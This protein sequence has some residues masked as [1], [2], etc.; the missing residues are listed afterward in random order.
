MLLLRFRPFARALAGVWIALCLLAAPAAADR[1]RIEAFLK[2]TGFDVA[3]ESIQFAA[4]SAPEMLGVDPG[5]FGSQWERM[6]T[7]VFD[8]DVMLDLGLELLEPTLQDDLLTHA[9]DF[10]AS[11][12]GQRLVE[13][14]NTAH[15]DPDDTARRARGADRMADMVANGSPRIEL[16]Q[17]MTKAIDAS[18]SGARALQEIQFRFLMAASAAGV[19]DLNF[20][21]DELRALLKQQEGALIRQIRQNGLAGAAETYHA[22]SDDDLLAYVEALEH[23]KMQQVYQLLNAVQYEIM[24]NRFEVL[25]V[26]MADLTPVEDI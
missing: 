15:M 21:A 11:D 24:A 8:P 18:G 5:L 26:R 3:L 7:A 2:V 16:F 25:A 19:I 14:E 13:A 17:R 4:S 23:P 22:F 10:Y 1:D 20:D 6:S 12:L 9:A